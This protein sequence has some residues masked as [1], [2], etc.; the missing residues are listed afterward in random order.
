MSHPGSPPRGLSVP[1]RLEIT[2][3]VPWE[4]GHAVGRDNARQP[5]A[6]I[7]TRREPRAALDK[8]LPRIA[9]GERLTCMSIRAYSF[10]GRISAGPH[11]SP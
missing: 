8:N 6:A 10:P 1:S 7:A 11:S 5:S 3:L 4:P 2:T 9:P